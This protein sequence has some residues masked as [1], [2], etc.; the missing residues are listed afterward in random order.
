MFVIEKTFAIIKPHA[1]AAKHTGEIITLIEKN[2]FDV[3]AMEKVHLT[4]KQAEIFYAIHKEKPFFG[5]LVS[6]VTS[7]PAIVLVLQKD[8]ATKAWR[9]FMGATDPEKA[10]KGTIRKL[11]GES[12]DLNATHGSDSPENAK[13]EIKQFFPTII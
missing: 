3:I 10:A 11:F 8:N 2:G 1:V 7:G 9:D 5:A 6:N 4:K 13:L 12:I